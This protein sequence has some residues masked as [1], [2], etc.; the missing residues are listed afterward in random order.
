M[1]NRNYPLKF[2]PMLSRPQ[3]SALGMRPESYMSNFGSPVGTLQGE[4]EFRHQDICMFH[5]LI[6]DRLHY[7][8]AALDKIVERMKTELTSN[9]TED[10]DLIAQARLRSKI[11]AD[12]DVIRSIKSFADETSAIGLWALVEQF[13]SQAYAMAFPDTSGKARKRSYAWDSLKKGF[14][15]AGITISDCRESSIIEELRVLNN[16]IK[17]LNVVDEELATFQTFSTHNDQRI[18]D[19]ELPM[20]M[21]ADGVYLFLGDLLEKAGGGH[22]VWEDG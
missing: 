19:I 6:Y 12:D 4:L 1:G 17:H 11:N 7:E 20:Q 21:Y 13:S 5:S 8:S 16:K 9:Y 15:E 22:E 2:K 14:A 3:Q 10:A 18:R